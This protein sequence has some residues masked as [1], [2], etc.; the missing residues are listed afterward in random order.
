MARRER[1]LKKITPWDVSSLW[2][3]RG[4]PAISCSLL[5]LGAAPISWKAWRLEV[6]LFFSWEIWYILHR[7]LAEVEWRDGSRVCTPPTTYKGGAWILTCR[8]SLVHSPLSC[9]RQSE[10]DMGGSAQLW[11]VCLGLKTDI[12]S[13]FPLQVL[14]T[15]LRPRIVNICRSAQS[16]VTSVLPSP[17]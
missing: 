6:K 5:C 12:W 3:H 14:S 16:T 2:E 7:D 1:S 4:S 13:W 9:Q 17:L 8:L 10:P 11:L 15:F